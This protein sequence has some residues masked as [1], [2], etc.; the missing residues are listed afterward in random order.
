MSD[1]TRKVAFICS[2]GTLDM[3]YPAL[4]MGWA[5][6]GNGIDVTIFFTFWGMNVIRKENPPKVKKDFMSKMF[7]WMMPCGPGKLGLSK[8]NMGGMGTSMMKGV[9]KKKNVMNLPQL[10]AL[11]QAEPNIEMI[12][13]EMSMDVMGI[14]KEELIDGIELAG[15]GSF[16]GSVTA[17]NSKGT[18]S[19]T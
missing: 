18:I 2:K 10:I 11:A 15:V 1:D 19:F 9:M 4:V 5:A 14:K 17:P 8:M 12:A 3:A 16:V 6:L 7:G 13:C